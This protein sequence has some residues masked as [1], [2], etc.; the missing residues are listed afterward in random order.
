[1]SHPRQIMLHGGPMNG[2]CHELWVERGCVTPDRI[3]LVVDDT[4]SEYERKIA[5]Y[6]IECGEGI[7]LWTRDDVE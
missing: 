1:M 6:R 3:G 5:W 4:V 2:V 7:Y